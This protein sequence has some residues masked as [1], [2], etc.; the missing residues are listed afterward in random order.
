MTRLAV[1]L[2]VIFAFFLLATGA[3]SPAAAQTPSTTG[4]VVSL[5]IVSETHQTEIEEHFRDFVNYIALKFSPALAMEGKVIVVPKVADL[6]RLLQQGAVDFYMESPYPTYVIN[7]VYAAARLLLRRWKSG[8]AE[9]QSFIFTKRNSGIS[10]LS[11][12]L[13]KMMV[14]EDPESTSGYFLPKLF[15]QRNGFKFSQKNGSDATI[16]AQEIGYI[17]ARSQNVV[18]VVLAGGATA[19]AFSD[20]DY[21]RLD[22]R[23]KAEISVLAQT[24]KLPRHLVS[25]RNDLPAPVVYR[26]RE[27]LLSMHED[28]EGRRILQKTDDT[29][30]FDFL[31]GG[32][33]GMRRRLLETFYSPE[34]R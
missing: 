1:H 2:T 13:G 7:N 14:F 8:M 20:D 32:E 28:A 23:K 10:R 22:E 27:I 21:N 24:D 29:T 33:E 17:F 26:L 34:K 31:P 18:D 9:Y 5:G 4:K 15:L 11:D 6:G 12:L 16:S 19:G 30:K 25:V 3:S